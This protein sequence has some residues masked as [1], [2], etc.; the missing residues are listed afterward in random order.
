MGWL[1][2]GIGPVRV[3]TRG[4]SVG[5]GPVR[6][7]GSWRVGGN[8]GGGRSHSGMPL[9]HEEL[10]GLIQRE[11][12]A[13]IPLEDYEVASIAVTNNQEQS[14]TGLVKVYDLESIR[15]CEK[16][17]RKGRTTEDDFG[18]KVAVGAETGDLMLLMLRPSKH[19]G[20]FCGYIT[21][22]RRPRR[23]GGRRRMRIPARSR[24]L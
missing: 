22:V 5:F 11:M 1:S 4:A 14:R 3:G 15:S 18:Y 19:G 2:V 13:G 8:A 20:G 10:I 6:V 24:L 12:I 7:G 21:E 9:A 17:I 16:S 23:V